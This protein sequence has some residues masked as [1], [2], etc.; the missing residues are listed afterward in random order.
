M[1]S[2]WS[3]ASDGVAHSSNNVQRGRNES[4]KYKESFTRYL[5]LLLNSKAYDCNLNLLSSI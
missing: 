2:R 1:L 3:S 4:I 5:N